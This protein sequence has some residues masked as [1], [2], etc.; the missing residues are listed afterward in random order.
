MPQ[1]LFSQ[2]TGIENLQVKFGKEFLAVTSAEGMFEEADYIYDKLSRF[3]GAKKGFFDYF[4]PIN[5]SQLS[6][7]LS[8]DEP[9]I[10]LSSLDILAYAYLKA[11]LENTPDS[12]EV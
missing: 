2:L 9:S 7:S 6:A 1:I 10:H 5:K 4:L 11:V 12:L 8:N 3:L